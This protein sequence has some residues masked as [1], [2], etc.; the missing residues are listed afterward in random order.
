MAFSRSQKIAGK[1]MRVYVVT[2]RI[3]DGGEHEA[4]ML[5]DSRGSCEAIRAVTPQVA[6]VTPVVTPESPAVTPV[7]PVTPNLDEG[8]S[9]NSQREAGG[10]SKSAR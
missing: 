5:A 8:G 2:P 1:S 7:T 10:S 6:T 4:E 9:A 3:F